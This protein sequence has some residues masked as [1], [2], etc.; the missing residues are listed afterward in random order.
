MQNYK[1]ASDRVHAIEPEFAHLLPPGC[2]QITAEEAADLCPPPAPPSPLEQI[3]A[4]EAPLEDDLKKLQRQVLIKQLL[5]AACEMA[6][7]TPR[8]GVHAYLMAQGKG[9]ARLVNLEE[10]IAPLREL[11]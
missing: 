9:Y 2:V 11:L 5:D 3:R 1:D 4:L 6:P 7:G 10:A 8:E